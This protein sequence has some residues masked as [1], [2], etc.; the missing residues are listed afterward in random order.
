MRHCAP[1][2]VQVSVA[3]QQRHTIRIP[4]LERYQLP[5]PRTEFKHRS[6]T[7]YPCFLTYTVH[8]CSLTYP[9]YP[10]SLI[11]TVYPCSLTYTVY[12]CSLTYTVYP[13]SLTYTVHPCSLTDTRRALSAARSWKLAS[14]VIVPAM[15]SQIQ[16]YLQ[17]FIHWHLHS[18]SHALVPAE[19][20]VSV[21]LVHGISPEHK[22]RSLVGQLQLTIGVVLYHG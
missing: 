8:P 22:V 20:D 1:E 11:Y 14:A 13:C 16:W 9:V 3:H 5:A 2:L 18:P 10:C 7:V 17:T 6:H 21:P 15:P 4:L 19:S 12:P